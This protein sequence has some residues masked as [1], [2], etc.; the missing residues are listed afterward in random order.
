MLKLNAQYYRDGSLL[1]KTCDKAGDN[2]QLRPGQVRTS[3]VV[4]TTLPNPLPSR[5]KGLEKMGKDK[6]FDL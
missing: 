1:L 4:I 3:R 6:G 5:E 2:R